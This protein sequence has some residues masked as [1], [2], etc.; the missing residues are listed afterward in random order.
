MHQEKL[1]KKIIEGMVRRLDFKI[2]K[3]FVSNFWNEETVESLD[4]IDTM[5]TEQSKK[6][7]YYH[8]HGQEDLK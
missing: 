1:Q 8:V 7:V 4:V 3:K 2:K 6:K 5:S